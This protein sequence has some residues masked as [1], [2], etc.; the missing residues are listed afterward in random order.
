MAWDVE[1]SIEM[2]LNKTG[3]DKINYIAHSQGCSQILAAMGD[4]TSSYPG[5]ELQT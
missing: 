2:I 3:H 4:P 1:S 5:R